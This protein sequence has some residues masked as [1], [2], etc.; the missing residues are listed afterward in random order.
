MKDLTD[1]LAADLFQSAEKHLSSL[2]VS[3]FK[4][5]TPR[6]NF[7]KIKLTKFQ[8]LYNDFNLDADA[9]NLILP[10]AITETPGVSVGLNLSPL[11]KKKTDDEPLPVKELD[12]ELQVEPVLALESILEEESEELELLEES[13]NEPIL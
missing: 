6:V 5:Q 10:T 11:R 2:S 7:K 9:F 8:N 13:F 1:T 3:T 12:I 4:N